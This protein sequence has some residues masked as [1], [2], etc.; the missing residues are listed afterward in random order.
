MSEIKNNPSNW[1]LF[2]SGVVLYGLAYIASIESP[3]YAQ[4]LSGTRL[5]FSSLNQVF[6]TPLEFFF[7]VFGHTGAEMLRT[8]FIIYLLKSIWQYLVT[9]RGKQA[10]ITR[11]YRLWVSLVKILRNHVDLIKG[12]IK[13]FSPKNPLG[14]EEKINL[15]YFG[16]KFF[17]LPLL[18]SFAYGNLGGFIGDTLRLPTVSFLNGGAQQ[19]WFFTLVD[20]MFLVDVVLFVIGYLTEFANKSVVRSVEPTVLGWVVALMCY[21]PFNGI[22]AN[23]LPWSIPSYAVFFNSQSITNGFLVVMVLL[24]LIYVSA[25]VALNLKASNLTNRGIVMKG[26]YAI[27]RHPAYISKNLVWF[28]MTLPAILS[29]NFAALVTILFWIGIYYLRSITEERHLMQDPDYIEYC[30]KVRYR[31]IPGIF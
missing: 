27:V 7:S 12:R 6:Q 8:F 29:G 11:P 9:Y 3:Y 19:Q 2:S 10:P 24:Y 25:S 23:Y 13:P 20:G 30:K 15:L 28:L 18:V 31:F 22:T 21:P 17:Y 5:D 4:L 1:K 14:Q 16:V 26:P